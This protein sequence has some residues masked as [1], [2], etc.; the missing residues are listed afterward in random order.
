LTIGDIARR[1]YIQL[2]FLQAIDDDN[3]SA[4]PE[5]HVRLFVR[6]YARLVSI[7]PEELY[8]L[9]PTPS[10]RDRTIMSAATTG[11]DAIAASGSPLPSVRTV[12]TS[13]LGVVDERDRQRNR[14]LLGRLSA[15][16]GVRLGG[17]GASGWLL[18][19]AILLLLVLGGYFGIRA[20]L[21]AD[22]E[23]DPLE[24]AP[25]VDDTTQTHIIPRAGT[26]TTA[27]TEDGDSLTLEGRATGRVWFA[28]VSDGKKSEQGTIDSGE[29]KTWRAGKEFRISLSNA[30][31]LQLVLNGKSLG[32]LGPLRT[33][34]RNQIIQAGGVQLRGPA[35]RARSTNSSQS[36]SSQ[37]SSAPAAATSRS[38]GGRSTVTRPATPR[39]STSGRSARTTTNRTRRGQQAA[40]VI[41]TT[42]PR[43]TV[44]PPR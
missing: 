17:T 31:G 13:D 1:T 11:P 37:R 5:S 36:A 42:Q 20:L 35:A 15:G 19:G 22:G 7:D 26:D 29:M 30:G 18:R 3:F 23:G 28:I 40:P 41:I 10:P 32:T 16:K 39:R 21:T 4:V 38:A 33:S 9:L 25:P 14:A 27:A 34:V 2:P 44:L 8:A 24:S 43:G 12:S 6:E